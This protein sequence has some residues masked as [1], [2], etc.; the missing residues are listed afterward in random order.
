MLGARG[1]NLTIG[2]LKALEPYLGVITVQN[3]F[4]YLSGVLGSPYYQEKF[5]SDLVVPGPR[6]P[7]TKDP[8]LFFRVAEIGRKFVWFQTG[9]DDG[10]LRT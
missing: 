1:P 2:L 9:G 10:L 5:A 7:I 8:E 4:G 3:L 6:I